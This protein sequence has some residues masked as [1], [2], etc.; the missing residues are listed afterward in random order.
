MPAI[1]EPSIASITDSTVET[2]RKNFGCSGNGRGPKYG[3]IRADL[4][5]AVF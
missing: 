5:A 3:E 4:R 1:V 2:D